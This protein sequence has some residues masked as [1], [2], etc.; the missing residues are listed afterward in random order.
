VRRKLRP[1]ATLAHGARVICSR[2]GGFHEARLHGA[3]DARGLRH[4]CR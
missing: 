4:A 2:L 1:V 3:V